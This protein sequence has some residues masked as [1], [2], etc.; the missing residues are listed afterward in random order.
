MIIENIKIG[1][2]NKT[3]IIAEIG[4]NH[5]GDFLKAKK[6]IK[7]AKKSGA[8]AVKFQIINHQE[9]Y[10]KNTQSYNTF[11]Y[12]KLTIKELF[13]LKKFA[14]KNKIIFFA[15]PGDFSSLKIIQNLKLPAIKISSGLLT[16]TPL[17]LEA[18]KLKL[19]MIISTGFSKKRDILKAIKTIKKVHKK[20]A[21]LKCTSIYPAPE[22]K[23]NLSSIKMFQKKFNYLI[24]YSDHS[25]GINACLTAV[26]LGAKIIEKHF[27]L[28]NKQ[29]G[30]DHKISLTPKHFK[31]LVKNIRSIEKML[32]F[33][34][35]FS[36]S[37]E[38]KKKEFFHRTL[39]ANSYI[40]KGE[41]FT[42]SNIALK[43]TNEKGIKLKPEY[44][45]KIINKKARRNIKE[46]KLIK[47]SDF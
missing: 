33:E 47:Y 31:I 17:I 36:T 9:S 19:P 32:G 38:Q 6:L 2:K 16:N 24:G 1:K 7:E 28:D 12:R 45:F 43:R 13:R 20:I 8:D 30:A 15:T 29:T 27:T 11:G 22:K 14:K 3:F 23:L 37:E 4:V 42:K 26:S 18:A 46:D 21:I 39:V 10:C 40:K 25:L 34:N 41:K 5:D 44:F 35:I